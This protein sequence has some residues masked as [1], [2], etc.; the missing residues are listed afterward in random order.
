MSCPTAMISSSWDDM[1][2]IYAATRGE[3]DTDNGG[4]KNRVALAN[5]H[6]LRTPRP[7]F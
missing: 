3:E 4:K 7:G 1:G 2:K 6:S 5:H